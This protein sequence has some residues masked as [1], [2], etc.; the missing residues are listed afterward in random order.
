[1]TTWFVSLTVS[2]LNISS[3]PQKH[4]AR[5]ERRRILKQ[6]AH[7]QMKWSDSRVRDW[8][9]I[10]PGWIPSAVS[11]TD[12]SVTFLQSRYVFYIIGCGWD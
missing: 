1:M 2:R 3:G 9:L 10:E 12:S 5:T 6:G 11:Y 8:K 7:T 4:T